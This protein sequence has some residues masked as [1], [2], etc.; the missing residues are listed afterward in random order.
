MLT[1]KR[2]SFDVTILILYSCSNK[3]TLQT[4][5]LF[6]TRFANE[7]KV[8]DLLISKNCNKY[9]ADSFICDVV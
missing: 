2:K 4:E 1:K 9:T 3:K 7:T 5:L 8:T 6:E